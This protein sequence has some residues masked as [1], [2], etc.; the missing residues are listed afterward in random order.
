[1]T[2]SLL[3]GSGAKRW[4]KCSGSYILSK[5]LQDAGQ[6]V[7]RS[8]VFADQGTAAH[9]LASDCL[10]D[11]IE[12]FEHV[13]RVIDGLVVGDSEHGICPDAVALYVNE[14]RS[15][16][17]LNGVRLIEKGAAF[18]EVHP[19]L[20]GTVDFMFWLPKTGLWIIDYKNG[21]GIAVDAYKNEQLLYYAYLAYLSFPAMSQE[22]MNLPV[23][24][25][26]VQPRLAGQEPVKTYDTVLQEIVDF[27]EKTLVPHMKFLTSTAEGDYVPGNHCA[28]CPVMLDCP[29]NKKA[30]ADFAIDVD[31]KTMTDAQLSDYYEDFDAVKRFS[32]ALEAEIRLRLQTENNSITTAKLVATRTFRAWKPEAEAVLE[33]TFGQKAYDVKL[34]SPAAVEKLSA[35][36]KAIATEFGYM[37]ESSGLSVVSVDDKRSAAKYT[38][39]ADTFAAFVE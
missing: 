34:K 6:L 29:A 36:G 11:D 4:L 39:N 8:S 20:R 10:I 12:P 31:L 2:H 14:C 33:Q 19:D 22:D 18:P 5:T 1:M 7:N 25:R 35:K 27:G 26:I 16:V 21:A 30:Y 32:N 38:S 3:G 37:P 23:S 15:V 17:Q 24:L 28:F 9:T 13:G